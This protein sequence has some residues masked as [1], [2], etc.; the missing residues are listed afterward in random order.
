MYS[1]TEG[2]VYWDGKEIFSVRG[3][4]QSYFPHKENL[5]IHYTLSDAFRDSASIQERYRNILSLDKEGEV[6]W[7][8][9][10]KT[11]HGSYLNAYGSLKHFTNNEGI[12]GGV[13]LS[14]GYWVFHGAY[15]YRIN[16]DT[17]EILESV[18]TK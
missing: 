2:K 1:V 12:G 15:Q 6:I 7:R 5:I 11:S 18:F 4:I 13:D 17:G 9:C 16:P 3:T 14:D 10:P 8:I